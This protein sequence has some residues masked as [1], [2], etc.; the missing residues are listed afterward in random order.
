MSSDPLDRFVAAA[1]TNDKALM[2]SAKA[3]RTAIGQEE[4]QHNK[5]LETPSAHL[6]TS[7]ADETRERF[8]R[9]VLETVGNVEQ[10]RLWS[11]LSADEQDEFICRIFM[12][13]M[14]GGFFDDDD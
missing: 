3:F 13:P 5:R 11:E 14:L 8:E 7:K 12:P 6:A 9:D 2:V 4:S 1:T 10:K